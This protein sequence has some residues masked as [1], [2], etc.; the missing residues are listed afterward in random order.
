MSPETI[1]RLCDEATQRLT[2]YINR[3]A[4]QYI[5]AIHAQTAAIRQE[6]GL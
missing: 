5:R 3:A 2:Y 6:R 1:Q 4:G